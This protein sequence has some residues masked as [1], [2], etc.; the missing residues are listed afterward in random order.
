[1]SVVDEL[2]ILAIELIK[3]AF[4]GTDPQ[5]ANTIL[6]N[7]L[8]VVAAD[9]MG[10]ARIV[11]VVRELL[12]LRIEPIEAAAPCPD[13]K[14]PCIILEDATN[15]VVAQAVW[16]LRVM[17][18]DRETVAIV[19]VQPVLCAEPH[20]SLV[21]LQDAPYCALRQALLDRDPVKPDVIVPRTLI[22]R[23]RYA[24]DVSV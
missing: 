2:V 16:I 15:V 4:T 8:D 19:L 22:A 5:D 1:M 23:E 24:D 13:P 20:V 17:P 10:V 14:H 9:A 11:L 3:T 18:V 7:G 6:M 21:I 12:S